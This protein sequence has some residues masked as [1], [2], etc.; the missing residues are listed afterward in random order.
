[1]LTLNSGRINRTPSVTSRLAQ[2][3]PLRDFNG[4]KAPWVCQLDLKKDGAVAD[5]TPY[6]PMT[7]F[8]KSK[9]GWN[10]GATVMILDDAEGNSWVMKGF[11]L[12][13]KPKYTFAEFMVAGQ[14][15]CKSLPQGWKFRVVTLEK[16]PIES[17]DN[18]GGAIMADECF[19]IYDQII[20][21][22]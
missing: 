17:L 11:Q 2:T 1:M 7:V 12:V 18:E 5:V 3:G 20:G 14:D 4:I 16:D 9:I 13:L 19:N 8:R 6:E 22:R 15:K 21:G 10:K